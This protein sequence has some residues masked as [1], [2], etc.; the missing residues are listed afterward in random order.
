M[1]ER[2]E[3]G[4]GERLGSGLGGRGGAREWIVGWGGGAA[5][6]GVGL[7]E[8]L[9]GKAGCVKEWVVNKPGLDRI[10]LEFI[11]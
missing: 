2:E 1:R 8:V 7:S 5:G 11:G 3:G 4:G 6:R 9:G 10:S